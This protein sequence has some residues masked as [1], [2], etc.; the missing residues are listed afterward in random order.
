MDTD[1]PA[2]SFFGLPA[3]LRDE[4]YELLLYVKRDNC[5]CVSTDPNRPLLRRLDRPSLRLRQTCRQA[6]DEV[7]ASISR[8]GMLVCVY[9]LQDRESILQATSFKPIPTLLGRLV[10]EMEILVLMERNPKFTQ[11]AE[12]WLASMTALYRANIIL[13]AQASSKTWNR[14]D[15]ELRLVVADLYSNMPKKIEGHMGITRERTR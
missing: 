12:S 10:Q 9:A 13:L 2:F 11:S 15:P 14:H 3:E 1:R 5:I 6:R 4:I 8:S 7:D